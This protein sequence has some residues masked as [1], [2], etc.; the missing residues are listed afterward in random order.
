MHENKTCITLALMSL[1][2]WK[3]IQLWMN[4]TFPLSRYQFSLTLHLL[5]NSLTYRLHVSA[6][7]GH[8]QAFTVALTQIHIFNCKGL[9]MA[10][11]GRNM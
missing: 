5:S 4:A 2:E 11:A 3:G 6:R 1:G 8:H 9:M 7:L 10:Q